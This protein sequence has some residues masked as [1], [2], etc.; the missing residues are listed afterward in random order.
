[1]AMVPQAAGFGIVLILAIVSSRKASWHLLWFPIVLVLQILMFTGLAL[2][3]S[4]LG[5]VIPD[6]GYMSGVISIALMQVSPIAYTLDMLPH[7]AAVLVT[8]SNVRSL[9]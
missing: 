2:F 6:L 4:S 3:M 9:Q 1:M 7:G 5:I 8:Y